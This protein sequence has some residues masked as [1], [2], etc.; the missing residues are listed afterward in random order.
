MQ[1]EVTKTGDDLLTGRQPKMSVSAGVPTSI[2]KVNKMTT[3]AYRQ[4]VCHNGTISIFSW[5]MHSIPGNN[6]RDTIT[7]IYGIM[8]AK[9]YHHVV[10][11]VMSTEYYH[12]NIRDNV[13]RILSPQHTG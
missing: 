11:G 12:H 4:H 1:V 3:A 8:S 13:D 5:I 10:C 7:L 2:S 9:Y 6:R